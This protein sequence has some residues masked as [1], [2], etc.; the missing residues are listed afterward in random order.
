MKKTNESLGFITCGSDYITSI[1]VPYLERRNIRIKS[2]NLLNDRFKGFKATLGWR[3]LSRS[4]IEYYK[5]A[6]LL[7]L[8]SNIEI[9]LYNAANN[10]INEIMDEM[11]V[12]RFYISDLLLVN[13]NKRDNLYYVKKEESIIN[14]LGTLVCGVYGYVENIAK[15]PEINSA[16]AQLTKFAF[17]NNIE[18]KVKFIR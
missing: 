14:Q 10:T 1:K 11:D 16:K 2:K 12:D 18:E 13:Q 5:E 8:Q 6:L 4:W 15:D 3:N 9:K 17:D 7:L